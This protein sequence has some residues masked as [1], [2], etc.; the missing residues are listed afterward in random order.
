MT[1]VSNLI[2][3]LNVT[4]QDQQ[5]PFQIIEYKQ[6]LSVTPSTAMAAY[7]A[8]RMNVRK[9]QVICDL[10]RAC[11]GISLQAGVMQWMP[12]DVKMITGVKGVGD[13][14][15]KSFRGICFW[16]VSNQA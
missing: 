4:L 10:S 2:N 11:K 6:D 8:S 13:F 16:R 9:R 12:G 15:S 5:D 1:S 7:F 14:I 3:N